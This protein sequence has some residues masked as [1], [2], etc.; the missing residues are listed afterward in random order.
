VGEAVD[1]P[2]QIAAKRLGGRLVGAGGPAE[3]E[4]DPAGKKRFERAELLGDDQ[5]SMVGKH[6]AAR[7]DADGR[8]PG[9]D[10]GQ[11]HRGGGAGDARHRMML[12]HPEPLI[13]PAFA[14][15]GQIERVAERP[16]GIAALDD[17][18]QVEDGER[19]HG[20]GDGYGSH[21]RHPRE[22]GEPVRPSHWI[23]AFAGMTRLAEMTDVSLGR[24]I[25]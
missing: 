3:A 10:I 11:G 20:E 2:G 1:I 13:A 17:R 15:T 25:A 5:R 18:G 23:P 14:V 4:I 7:A 8:G 22:S 19:D 9:A 12:G 21:S 16:A 24:F 6:D